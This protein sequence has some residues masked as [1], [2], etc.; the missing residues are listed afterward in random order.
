MADEETTQET[1]AEAEEQLEQPSAFSKLLEKEIKPKTDRAQKQVDG[2]VRTLAEYV[3]KD[4]NLVSPDVVYT[5]EAIKTKIDEVLT[6]QVNEILHNEEFQKVE[7]AWRGLHHLVNNSETD[8]M[9]KIRVMNISKAEL[10]K[11][12]KK[13][14]GARWDTSPLFKKVYGEE[15]DQ[16]GGEPY[17]CLVGD[18]YFDHSA[19]DVELLGEI[20]KIAA[21]AHA[22]FISGASHEVMQMESWAELS[23]PADLSKRFGD[24]DYAAWRSLRDSE[25]S[26]YLGLAMPRFLAR[27]PYEQRAWI[28]VNTPGPTPPMPWLPISTGL[29]SSTV[30]VRGFV[31]LKPAVRWKVCRCTP[32]PRM[33][34]AWI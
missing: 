2:A 23:D 26:R 17:G 19:P 13:F 4:E 11:T 10:S 31:V 5:I 8:E 24:A 27:L 20:S 12:L 30:G 33:T 29:L 16:M 18:Y 6:Q 14:K 3:L 32:F 9:L 15:F 1:P 28:P 21:S 25:D 7:S 34:P 22:P